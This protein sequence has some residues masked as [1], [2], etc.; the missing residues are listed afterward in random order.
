MEPSLL[1]CHSQ[2]LCKQKFFLIFY[3]HYGLDIRDKIVLV[4]EKYLQVVESWVK[5]SWDSFLVSHG[6][7]LHLKAR[8]EVDWERFAVPGTA[9]R[10]R[11]QI[12]WEQTCY[13][14]EKSD[15]RWR[16]KKAYFWPIWLEII[17]SLK[18]MKPVVVSYR[19]FSN[20][21][22]LDTGSDNNSSQCVSV[23]SEVLEVRA[24]SLLLSFSLF[25]SFCMC[26]LLVCVRGQEKSSFRNELQSVEKINSCL[27]STRS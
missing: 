25:V 15:L 13:W 2:R 5:S 17:Y 10:V 9:M 20:W 22:G 19:H 14:C 26:W 23:N 1:E 4:F 12:W 6:W 18:A 7:T 16:S 27:H 24:S 11:F 8:N 3:C 21:F